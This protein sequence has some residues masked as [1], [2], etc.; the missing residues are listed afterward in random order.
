LARTPPEIYRRSSR[1]S[2][3]T[4]TQPLLS[5]VLSWGE[6][7]QILVSWLILSI[8]FSADAMISVQGFIERFT[9][10]LSTVGLGFVL[11][12]LAHRY[13]ARRYGC[14]SGFRIWPAGLG[15]ALVLAILSR[16]RFIFAAPGAVYIVPRS[17]FGITSKTNGMIAVSGAATNLV[18]AAA[19]LLVSSLGGSAEYVG[20]YGAIINLWLAAFNLIPLPQFD[21]AK[22]MTW[23][24]KIWAVMTILAWLSLI[25]LA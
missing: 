9:L 1:L 19:F 5:R 8:C 7:Q 11:H 25:L 14:W 16:G 24:W 13:F 3:E 20:H 17:G 10:S 12:E 21:G 15:L 2:F 6:A 23:D 4:R 22:V 18:L